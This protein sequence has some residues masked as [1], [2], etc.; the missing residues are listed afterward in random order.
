MKSNVYQDDFIQDMTREGYGFSY[1]GA[2][3]LFDYIEQLEDDCDTIVEYDP[4]AFRCEYTEYCI[5]DYINDYYELSEDFLGWLLDREQIT[6]DEVKIL[7]E[8][9]Y[10]ALDANGYDWITLEGF[11]DDRV[12][13]Q[14]DNIITYQDSETFIITNH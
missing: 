7:T 14:Y 3:L 12:K 13:D 4:I 11:F 2:R 10:K 5:G 9:N 6:E 8:D 1:E